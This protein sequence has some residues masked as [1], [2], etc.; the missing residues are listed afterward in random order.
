MSDLAPI[1]LLAYNRPWHTEQVLRALKKNIL[2]EQ[3]KLKTES[4]SDDSLNVTSPKSA[5][6]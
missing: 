3:T 4:L 6:S 1:V 2:A 5:G